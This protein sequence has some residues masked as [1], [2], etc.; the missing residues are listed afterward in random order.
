MKNVFKNL[1]Y[2]AKIYGIS[3]L[4]EGK[5]KSVNELAIDIFEYERDNNIRD[6]FYP[7]VYVK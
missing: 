5:P 4:T 3:V 6:G 1:K 2:Y 7:F